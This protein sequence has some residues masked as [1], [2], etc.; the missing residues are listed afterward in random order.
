MSSYPACKGGAIL[1]AATG[2]ACTE[3]NASPLDSLYVAPAAYYASPDSRLK[4]DHDFGVQLSVGSHLS[5]Q[6]QAELISEAT[7]FKRDDGTDTYKQVGASLQAIFSPLDELELR[8]LFIGGAGWL[9]TSTSNA[10]S[11]NRP[12]LRAGAGLQWD[13]PNSA[14][15]VRGTA[16][17][18]H[19]FNSSV[20]TPSA[21]LNTYIYSL[22]VSYRFG[23]RDSRPT[24][25]ERSPTT[26]T[27]PIAASP[28]PT[29]KPEPIP[30]P[31]RNGSAP[32]VDDQDGD[33]ILD[34][35]DKCPDTPQSA[36]VD[37]DGCPI[38]LK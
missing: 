16:I 37:A 21:G 12:L 4:A 8:P 38:R 32:P 27:S 30:A 33:G 36:V 1:L 28:A 14:W 26:A 6:W 22:G 23:G 19:E 10:G 2:L 35:Q 20:V 25:V 24:E 31:A 34:A 11:S 13:I 17:W 15:G 9:H 5:R 3:A 7:K 18:R 29:A